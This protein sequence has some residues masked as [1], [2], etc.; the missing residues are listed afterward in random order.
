MVLH[1][2]HV[3]L[4]E[5]NLGLTSVGSISGQSIAGI[6]T[7][8]SHGSGLTYPSMSCLVYSL[9]LL[10]SD[11]SVVRTSRDPAGDPDLFLAT[12]C[13]LGSTG[14]IMTVTLQCEKRF[15]LREEAEN[16]GFHDFVER[17][18]EIV[19]SAEHVRC[20]WFGQRGVVRVS[21]CNRTTEPPT[22]AAS[23]FRQVFLAYHVVQFTLFLGRYWPIWNTWTA[24]FASWLMKEKSVGVDDSWK[25]FNVDCRYPQHTIEYGLPIA[26]V[27]A[28]LL[29]LQEFTQRELSDPEGL[30][31]H[32]PFEIRLSEADDI[33]LSPAYG[34][35]TCWIGVAQ[36]KPY[37]LPVPYTR[38]LSYVAY[39]LYSHGGRPHWAK[40]HPF[41]P[42]DFQQMYPMWGRFNEVRR[43]VDRV[44]MW[45]SEWSRRCFGLE[46]EENSRKPEAGSIVVELGEGKEARPMDQSWDVYRVEGDVL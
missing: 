10:L 24:I 12:L 36:Y 3:H 2:L 33:W 40:E 43:H 32:F 30:R 18:A 35:R 20:W 46:E 21:R 37:G 45:E 7:T 19:A 8:A 39:I 44:G 5:H 14:F 38:L 42:S 29:A 41:K 9:T 23:W 34:R 27:P 28:C 4:A 1:E 25:I 31:P 13:G 6:V 15:R 26:N 22:K 11:G 16:V 17:F